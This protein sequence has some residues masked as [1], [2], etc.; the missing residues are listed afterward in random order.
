MGDLTPFQKQVI[1]EAEK[2]EA[3]RKKEKREEA[4]NGNTGS[5]PPQNS[6][7][8]GGSAG[9]SDM[10]HEETVRYVNKD[11]N[12]DHDVHDST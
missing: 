8:P 9:G 6:R 11:L 5:S 3:E 10:D 4:R 1:D 12:P 2:F 7:A